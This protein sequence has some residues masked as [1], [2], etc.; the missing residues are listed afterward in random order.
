MTNSLEALVASMK[1]AAEKATSGEWLLQYGDGDSPFE[2]DDAIISREV[3]GFMAIAKI[4]GAHPDS[5][6]DE[7]FQQEQQANAEF[8]AAWQPE[9]A[10]ALIA[11]LAQ[12]E[13]YR[14]SAFI[15]ANLW[16]DKFVAA[17]NRIAELEAAAVKPVKQS[18][19][20]KRFYSWLL[21]NR[22]HDNDFCASAMEKVR[23]YWAEKQT[24]NIHA[25]G[26]D[27]GRF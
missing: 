17:E 13:A 21:A 15:T 12:E 4:E 26:S 22:C 23:E 9:N 18:S 6:F 14:K 2:S 11:A 8:I 5:G 1:A 27:D 25:E 19:D 16:R 24:A 20:L 3:Q 10:L 7:A